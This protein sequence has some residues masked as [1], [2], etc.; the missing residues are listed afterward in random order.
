MS[1]CGYHLA[2]R[3]RWIG[4]SEEQM[5]RR[6]PFVVQNSRF[7]I[8][9]KKKRPNLASKVLSKCVN[10]VSADWLIRF[11]FEPVLLE[12]FL[13]PVRFRGTCYKASGWTQVGSTRGFRRDGRGIGRVMTC[14]RSL[15]ALLLA[16]G[17]ESTR[18]LQ[19]RLSGKPHLLLHLLKSS[20]A[21]EW[22]KRAKPYAPA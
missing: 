20:G 15:A 13:D 19:R 16:R 18:V 7:L 4:W 11:G 5:T 2:D 3:D 10:R 17:K 9:G 21:A 8:L 14:F 6:R 12:T 1:G 22:E